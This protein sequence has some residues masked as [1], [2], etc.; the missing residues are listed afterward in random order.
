MPKKGTR[1]K[2]RER[3]HVESG[4]AH[5]R[6]TFNN[7]IITITDPHGNLVSWSSAGNQGFKG[8]RK[9]TPFA[10]QMAAEAAAKVAMEHGMRQIEVYVKGPGAGREAAI[11]SLQA[12]GLE[13]NMIKDV[14]PIPHNG[15][16]PPKRRR[17]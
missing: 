7:T 10:A 14:T 11:R 12:A 13:V 5:I 6:S 1:T 16:R 9:G 15:C 17:V 4:A 3:K 8:S 2:R